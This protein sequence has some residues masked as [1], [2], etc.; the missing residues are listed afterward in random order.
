MLA[1]LNHWEPDESRLKE[2][3]V[4]TNLQ[5]LKIKSLSFINEVGVFQQQTQEEQPAG[6]HKRSGIKG[7][8]TLSCTVSLV[9]ECL[10]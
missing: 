4:S 3:T 8:W 10:I 7:S 9:R 1:G 6:S 2:V 5:R